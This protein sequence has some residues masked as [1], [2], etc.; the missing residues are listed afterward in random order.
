[1]NNNDI[2]N[3]PRIK[4]LIY[5]LKDRVHVPFEL[6]V[7][8]IQGELSLEGHSRI[9]SHLHICRECAEVFRLVKESISSGD[10]DEQQSTSS[11]MFVNPVVDPKLRLV[12]I[13]NSKRD[14]IA[15]KVAKLLIVKES[16]FAVKPAIVAYRKWLNIPSEKHVTAREEVTMVAFTSG[17]IEDMEDFETIINS[18]R[19]SDYI[20]DLLVERCVSFNEAMQKLAGF[21]DD[22]LALFE[23]SRPEIEFKKKVQKILDELLLGSYPESI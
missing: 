6:I 3:N 14:V 12:S 16:W 8:D 1:M 17:S 2:M 4:R 21:V 18:V 22:G 19:F 5:E 23:R 13:V 20:C 11:N 7:A 15:E 10:I 9:E